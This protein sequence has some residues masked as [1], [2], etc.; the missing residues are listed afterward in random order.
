MPISTIGSNSLNQTSDL[1]INGVTVG[2]GGGSQS[3]STSVGASAGTATQ[4]IG[5][6]T[7]VGYQANQVTT[8]GY[9]NTAV[10]ALALSANVSGASN[11]VVG[12]SSGQLNTGNS[13]SVLGAYAFQANTS[14][15]SNVAIGTNALNA[16]TT[17]SDN[18]AVGYQALYN[19]VTGTGLTAIGKGAALAN[20]GNYNTIVGWR[21]GEAVTSGAGNTIVGAL[22]GSL[23]TGSKNT[24]IGGPVI[25]VSNGC[26]S[27]MTTGSSNTIIGNYN[28]NQGSLDIRTASNYVVLSDGDGNLAYVNA[29]GSNFFG[30]A[31]T[32]PAPGYGVNAVLVPVYDGSARPG[33]R[34]YNT[35]TGSSAS[36]EI[37]FNR[38]GSSVGQI[39]TTNNATAYITSSDYRLKQDIVSMTG[40]LTTIAQ[41]KPVKY[42]WKSDDREGQGFIAHELQEVFPEAVYGKKDGLDK[43]NNPEYQ[44]ID[45]SFLV[46]TLT[47]A[48]QELKTIVDAQAA[49]IAE[50]KAKVA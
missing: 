6:N 9:S 38:N 45:T 46:A 40:A 49:E 27:A 33:M 19:N 48:I 10:G 35:Q 16:N 26:A 37:N 43:D 25:G 29:N 32:A 36:T 44:G 7:S 47:A 17:A 1:T 28:G 12:A 39:Y 8:T 50:L 20:T 2:K 18:T 22:A 13:N 30:A 3:T 34:M 24:F 5:Y 23:S 21:T 15:A 42:K 41:L 4:T 11:T 31:N 14:G